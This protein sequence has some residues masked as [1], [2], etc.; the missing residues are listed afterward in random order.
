[1]GLIPRFTAARFYGEGG[2]YSVL[3]WRQDNVYLE[4]VIIRMDG[5]WGE[6]VVQDAPATN[7]MVG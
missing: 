2:R 6:G 5:G 4:D 1:M 7:P 3:A